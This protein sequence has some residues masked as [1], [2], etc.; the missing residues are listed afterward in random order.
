M[1]TRRTTAIA[2][3]TF[4]LGVAA[5]TPAVAY[6]EAF[7]I[8]P[9]DAKFANC[10]DCVYQIGLLLGAFHAASGT[11]LYA[12]TATMVSRWLRRGASTRMLTSFSC[13]LLY[14]ILLGLSDDLGV[15]LTRT[16]FWALL[17]AYPSLA[18]LLAGGGRSA[19]TQPNSSRQPTSF[20]GG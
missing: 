6:V 13:G 14:S 17:L 9:R 10:P 20:A 11:A 5:T 19:A 18:F 7:L 3:L 2:A 15:P 12:A 8:G 1:P 4:G 16:S